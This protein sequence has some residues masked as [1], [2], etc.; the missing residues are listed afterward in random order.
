[1]RKLSQ[2]QSPS[3]LQRP[4]P[5]QLYGSARLRGLGRHLHSAV[6]SLVILA[7]LSPLALA[8]GRGGQG[9]GGPGR[10]GPGGMAQ[11]GAGG[12]NAGG[13]NAAGE[14][15]DQ[16][17]MMPGGGNMQSNSG[18]PTVEQLAQ[19]L[20]ANA[21]A[22]GSGSLDIT[23]LQTALTGLRNMMMQSQMQQNRQGGMQQAGMQQAGMQRTGMRQ[24]A[25]VA[26]TQNPGAVA[27]ARGGGRN[28][29]AARWRTRTLSR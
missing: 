12:L 25:G 20:M 10:G 13:I 3:G 29:G 2:T 7:L 4:L 9:R 24:A 14:Q 18:M 28:G 22:D 17:C 8:Q 27:G 5:V 26:G 15:G 16:A 1:M 23:E 11:Q 6:G 21:D 19:V